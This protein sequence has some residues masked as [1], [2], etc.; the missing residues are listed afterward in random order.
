[1]ALLAKIAIFPSPRRVSRQTF[2]RRPYNPVKSEGSSPHRNLR[3][4]WAC[5]VSEP[6]PLALRHPPSPTCTRVLR[7]R[8]PTAFRHHHSDRVVVLPGSADFA[9][10]LLL[11]SWRRALPPLAR[12]F[13]VQNPVNYGVSGA[14]GKQQRVFYR[15]LRGPATRS[16]K[17]CKL[18]AFRPPRSTRPCKLRVFRQVRLARLAR[19]P[20]NCGVWSTRAA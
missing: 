1:M 19:K 18:R 16:P 20:V 9:R 13:L 14:G 15:V 17:P 4:F 12:D 10:D 8:R 7:A 6:T 3:G 5:D 11:P 2:F